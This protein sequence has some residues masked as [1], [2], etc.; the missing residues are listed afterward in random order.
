MWHLPVP[1]FPDVVHIAIS[2][3]CFP[4]WP[5]SLVSRLWG[6]CWEHQCWHHL[7]RHR[8]Q[9]GHLLEVW[10]LA[11]LM[12]RCQWLWF[13]AFISTQRL[14]WE[15]HCPTVTLPELSKPHGDIWSISF[16]LIS[17]INWG[18][19]A[20]IPEDQQGS[21]SESTWFIHASSLTWFIILEWTQHQLTLVITPV[22]PLSLMCM[23]CALR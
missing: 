12:P 22:A 14:F 20:C 3:V 21:L 7:S 4:W 2:I 15:S 1:T 19:E 5:W 18:H 16:L 9:S 17:L 10:G 8:C 6:L 13:V 11:K 23:V